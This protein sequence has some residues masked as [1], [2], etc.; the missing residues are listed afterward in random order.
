[1][2]IFCISYRRK[3]KSIAWKNVSGKIS[4][5]DEARTS[6]LVHMYHGG[7]HSKKPEALWAV[8]ASMNKRINFLA[9]QADLHVCNQFSVGHS[10]MG[11]Y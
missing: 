7:F 11:F 3:E 10:V 4:R 5:S 9:V 8:F 2:E 6:K 1:M